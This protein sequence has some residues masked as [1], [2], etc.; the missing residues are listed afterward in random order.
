MKKFLFSAAA[1]IAIAACVGSPPAITTPSRDARAEIEPYCARKPI[2]FSEELNPASLRDMAIA[3]KY[4][5]V[6]EELSRQDGLG[7]GD[8]WKAYECRV[9]LP[10]MTY[11]E[12]LKMKKHRPAAVSE[13]QVDEFIEQQ[14]DQL[15]QN[16]K[17]LKNLQEIF[18]S[19]FSLATFHDAAR[20]PDDL[21]ESE[22]QHSQAQATASGIKLKKSMPLAYLATSIGV[23][24]EILIL[25][26]KTG[27]SQKLIF[28]R[29]ELAANLH[30]VKSLAGGADLLHLRKLTG[31]TVRST[32][33]TPESEEGNVDYGN[34]V[35]TAK[36][37]EADRDGWTIQNATIYRS[38]R[39]TV[40]K[41][42]RI[43]RNSDTRVTDQTEIS[44]SMGLCVD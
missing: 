15:K 22:L 40:L 25:A 31:I 14:K 28:T 44:K 6:C 39:P 11:T 3:K 23:T 43:G 1:F 21:A 34:P 26:D 10:N 13:R 38:C 29:D 27:A 16:E 30:T 17:Y 24:V 32:P 41:S 7:F 4:S 9:Y 33:D 42:F 18:G 5:P 2:R 8:E 19:D 36:S 37:V 35:C 20:E 12:A